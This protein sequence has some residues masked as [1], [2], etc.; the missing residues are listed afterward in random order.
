MDKTCDLTAQ[1]QWRALT[2]KVLST[3]ALCCAVHAA[4]IVGRDITFGLKACT[5]RLDELCEVWTGMEHMG[6]A[7][8]TS[9]I[10]CDL[11]WLG[12]RCWSLLGPLVPWSVVWGSFALRGRNVQGKAVGDAGLRQG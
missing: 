1:T 10:G 2:A 4:G 3:A 5:C 11:V 8:F 7:G 12:W 6:K 9:L